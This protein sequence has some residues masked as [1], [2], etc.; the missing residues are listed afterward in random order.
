MRAFPF[1]G[2]RGQMTS[3]HPQLVLGAEIAAAR[4]DDRPIVALE[5]TILTHGMPYPQNLETARSVERIVRESGAVPATIAVL[6][7]TIHIGIDDQQLSRLAQAKAVRKLSRADL[8]FAVASGSDGSTTVAATMF[9]A[10]LAGIGV[11]ATGG[12]GGV[13]RGAETTFDISAD[14]EELARTPVAVVC[15]GAKAILDLPKTLE[16]LETRGVPVICYGSA[17]FPAFWSRSS[18]LPAPLRLDTVDEIARFL[19][20]KGALGLI[21]GTLVAN[22]IPPENEIAAAELRPLIDIAVEDARLQGVAGKAVTPFLLERLTALTG[23][24]SL[25][26]NIALIEHNARLGARLAAAIAKSA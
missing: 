19:A 18:G 2:V 3:F 16:A 26:A 10:H 23:G 22:P 17:E 5:T 13:H 8:P 25:A 1:E 4:S 9:C 14:L 15:A 7:G 12:I 21:G 6:G 24:R 11:F 20:V